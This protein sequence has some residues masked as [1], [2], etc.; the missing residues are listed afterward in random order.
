MK[1]LGVGLGILALFLSLATTGY[2]EG[3]KTFHMKGYQFQAPSYSKEIVKNYKFDVMKET[4]D[5]LENADYELTIILK[6]NNDNNNKNLLWASQYKKGTAAYNSAIRILNNYKSLQQ[7]HKIVVCTNNKDVTK[8]IQSTKEG[9]GIWLQNKKT[10]FFVSSRQVGSEKKQVL[11]AL[12]MGAN[13]AAHLIFESNKK[14]FTPNLP[15][16]LKV[17]DTVS[18]KK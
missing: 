5:K 3:W 14:D 15:M 13:G 6:Q 7:A 8:A 4:V 10:L 9:T 16:F 2:A 18:F 11:I 1:Q 17:V 12:K